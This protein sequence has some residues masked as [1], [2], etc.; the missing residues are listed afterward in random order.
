MAKNKTKKKA[1]AP[2]KT[3][4]TK[5]KQKTSNDEHSGYAHY[6]LSNFNLNKHA[7]RKLAG[8]DNSVSDDDAA[9][10]L[11]GKILYGIVDPKKL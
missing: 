9:S 3:E 6:I 1:A 5:S 4:P 10:I 2:D 11:V 8:V 7:W